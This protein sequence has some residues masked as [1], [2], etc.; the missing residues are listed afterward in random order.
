M[1][2]P[3]EVLGVDEDATDEAIKKAYLRKVRETPPERDAE[4]FRRIR[5]AYELI[6]TGK[7]R[8][9]YRLFHVDTSGLTALLHQAC[10]PSPPQRPAASTLIGALIEG[11]VQELS[12]STAHR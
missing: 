6:Q 11:F 1:N 12:D 2:T 8:C 9:E 5:D 10:E 4:A 3:F 7:Q